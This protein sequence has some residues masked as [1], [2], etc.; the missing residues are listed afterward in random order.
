MP[1]IFAHRG[2]HV[3]ERENTVAAFRGACELGVAGVEL[4]VRRTNDGQLV[5]HHDANVG[6]IVIADSAKASLPSYV[7]TLAEA[8]DALEGV[9]VNIEVKNLRQ[10]S[11]PTYDDTGAFARDVVSLVHDVGR[12]PS[13]I[14]SSFDLATCEVLKDA[15]PGIPVGWLLWL[16]DLGQAIPLAHERGL[17]AV[18]PSFRRVARASVDLARSFGLEVNVWTVNARTDILAMAALGVDRIITDDPALALS[19]VGQSRFPGGG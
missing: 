12:A 9:T 8:L 17:D 10:P 7:P 5:V 19:L 18:N 16:E 14:F 6:A 1:E 4:D 13:V 2:L 11:E 3:R 15:A